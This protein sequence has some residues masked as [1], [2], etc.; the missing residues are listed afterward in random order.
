MTPDQFNTTPKY[1]RNVSPRTLEQY[2]CAF[3]AFAGAPDRK[4]TMVERKAALWDRKLSVISVNTYLQCKRPLQLVGLEAV[5]YVKTDDLSPPE[6][7]CSIPAAQWLGSF[8]CC[9]TW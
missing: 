7:T 4:A 9:V 8:S 3:E 6:R 1:I 2:D 5:D